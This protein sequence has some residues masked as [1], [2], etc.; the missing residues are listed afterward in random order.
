MIERYVCLLNINNK[1]PANCNN[2]LTIANLN[3]VFPGG[4]QG[5]VLSLSEGGVL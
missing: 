3:E 1:N 4:N 2:W 5:N